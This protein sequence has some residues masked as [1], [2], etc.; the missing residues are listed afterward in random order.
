MS[1][2]KY[3]L[4]KKVFTNLSNIK[5]RKE[6]IYIKNR[7]R[8]FNYLCGSKKFM[9]FDW[10]PEDNMT[11][12]DI[13]FLSKKDKYT[14]YI[15]EVITCQAYMCE[16]AWNLASDYAYN[17]VELTDD[18]F[19]KSVPIYDKTGHI[20]CYKAKF[21]NPTFDEFDG[22]TRYEYI[23]K[24]TQLNLE[25]RPTV[26]EEI[27]LSNTSIHGIYITIIIDAPKITIHNIEDKIDL[28]FNNNEC[29]WKNPN[30][31]PEENLIYEHD[32]Y[33]KLNN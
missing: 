23:K 30:P 25:K 32:W 9:S 14:C 1:K 7:I 10:T 16:Q 19:F 33:K 8:T 29:V 22:L 3:A 15:G 18:D 24:Q 17:L 5:R 11:W 6:V 31:V 2:R 20:K 26:Y 21:K 13:A 27:K 4:D 28:F 12:C